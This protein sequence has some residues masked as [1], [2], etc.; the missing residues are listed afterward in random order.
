M[1]FGCL[2]ENIFTYYR[3]VYRNPYTTEC[4]YNLTCFCYL[5]FINPCFNF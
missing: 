4:F 2:G 5:K 3:F 1:Y